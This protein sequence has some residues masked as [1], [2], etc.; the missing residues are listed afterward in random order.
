MKQLL[1]LALFPTMILAQVGI[2]T[3]TPLSDLHIAGNTSTIR[4]ESLSAANTPEY[5][6]GIK[7]ARNFVTA[8]GDVTIDPSTNNGVGPNGT[9][10]PIKFLLS[11]LNFIP[12]GATNRGTITNNDT[13]VT[14]TTSLITTVPFTSPR[15]SLI[16]VKYSIS[17]LL[18]STDLNTA[19]TQFND[20][21]A[22]TFK[23]YFCVD[24]D[25]NGLSAAELSRKFGLNGQCYSSGD[26]GILGYSFTN[27]HGYTTIPPGTHSLHFFAEVI[28]GLNKFTSIGFGGVEDF[29]RIRVYN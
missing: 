14:N 8:Y 6:D 3:S 24:I 16:E 1:L 13:G 15:N 11:E 23:I 5:N 22:R 2:G 26:Q 27:G 12:N 17:A 28:D 18:S 25:N 10:S 19:I 20:V 9:I 7:P 29:L 21:S 4:I